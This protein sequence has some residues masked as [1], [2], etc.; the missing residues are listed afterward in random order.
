MSLYL[1]THFLFLIKYKFF[2][3][4][5]IVV[6]NKKNHFLANF[7]KRTKYILERVQEVLVQ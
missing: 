7:L 3:I 6:Y 5:T 2:Y 1:N 4:K